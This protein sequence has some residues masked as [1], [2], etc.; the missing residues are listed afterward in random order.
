MVENPPIHIL[1]VAEL[2]NLN[3]SLDTST[4]TILGTPQASE[5]DTMVIRVTDANGATL[6]L[7]FSIKIKAGTGTPLS[8]PIL[9]VVRGADTA[10][11][12]WVP[13][14]MQ[15]LTIGFFTK[16]RIALVLH[17]QMQL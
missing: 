4:G 10:T 17:F 14:Q 1:L 9:S 15:L 3:L 12:S 16:E 6:D 7:S 11:V 13:S 2:L 5:T 8:T